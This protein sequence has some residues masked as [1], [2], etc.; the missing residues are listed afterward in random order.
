MG[1]KA[2]SLRRDPM[3]RVEDFVTSDRPPDQS[4]EVK[5]G[6]GEPAPPVQLPM[7]P[8]DLAQ[9]VTKL[10]EDGKIDDAI[11]FVKSSPLASQNT[12]VW[13]TLL[14]YIF[15]S[16]RFNAGYSLF[17]DMKRR[18]FKP[19]P[20][21]WT[22]LFQGFAR[23]AADTREPI[24]ELFMDRIS[25]AY[26]Q[27]TKVL[28]GLKDVNPFTVEQFIIPFNA[29]LDLLLAIGR[30]QELYNVFLS[31]EDY[32]PLKADAV[33]YAIVLR[34]LLK[35]PDVPW[36]GETGEVKEIRDAQLARKVW[37]Q[38]RS[39]RKEG[40]IVPVDSHLFS[41]VLRL[42]S[43]SPRIADQQY[44]LDLI[45]E[46]LG[47]IKPGTLSPT[48]GTKVP[49]N[50]YGQPLALTGYSFHLALL[51]AVRMR[52]FRYV[53]NYLQQVQDSA[54]AAN[55]LETGHMNLAINAHGELAAAK[56]STDVEE[57]FET[58]DW[59][60][61]QEQLDP[62][63]W[64]KVVPNQETFTSML[65][66]CWKG[67]N[68]YNFTRK[69][70][71]LMTGYDHLDF[72]K[73]DEP[74]KPRMRRGRTFLPDAQGMSCLIRS[75]LSNIHNI[76][77]AFRILKHLGLD[78]FFEDGGRHGQT[79]R[80]QR[81]TAFYRAKL[82]EA[83]LAAKSTAGLN[84]P[85]DANWLGEASRRS[86]QAKDNFERNWKVG[87]EL[88][89]WMGETLPWNSVNKLEERTDAIPVVA[90]EPKGIQARLLAA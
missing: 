83:I 14:M 37:D 33:T 9:R 41:A 42:M 24:S 63:V 65:R 23:R 80:D 57:A 28:E 60:I 2:G 56:G 5:E 76:H 74:K 81:V 4:N 75:S 79:R 40:I 11:S 6:K 49:R 21:T 82:G 1:T 55:V 86:Y 16:G 35:R 22:I 32:P 90:P 69:T 52:R 10:A 64:S 66:A 34:C 89:E 39:G 44:G 27:F 43:I 72:D 13:N 25:S 59:M 7:R 20:S 29:Y 85:F 62:R 68:N 3:H 61:R 70:F 88:K 47:L 54:W 51:L 12:I 18:G 73:D 36:K 67:R 87:M 78:R 58:I 19:I 50:T 17:I 15:K 26:T 31:V 46:Y 84:L 45:E 38:M 77:H 71:A 48:Q 30:H 53:L 8:Y